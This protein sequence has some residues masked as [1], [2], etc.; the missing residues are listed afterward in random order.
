VLEAMKME[1][2]IVSDK[3]GKIEVIN[4]SKGDV[5]REGDILVVI[6]KS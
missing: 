3:D 6:A 2:S 5:V 1:N 4:F